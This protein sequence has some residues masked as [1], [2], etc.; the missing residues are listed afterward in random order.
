MARPRLRHAAA[1]TTMMSHIVMSFGNRKA[2]FGPGGWV[3]LTEPELRLGVPDPETLILSP[4]IAGWRRERMPDV[5]DSAASELP[6][7]WVCEVLSPGTEGHDRIRKMECYRRARVGWAWI[8]DANARS[9]EVYEN[10]G[11][12][13]RYHSGVVGGAPARLQPFEA[14]EFDVSEWWA[15]AEDAPRAGPGTG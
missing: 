15:P 9:I 1:H 7:D 14:V 2:T 8:V 3:I 6:P 4:D 11:A 13:W 5:P 10:D 12:A